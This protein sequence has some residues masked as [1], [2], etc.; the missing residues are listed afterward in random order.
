MK[1]KSIQNNSNE[2][3]F[4]HFNIRFLYNISA[5]HDQGID[6]NYLLIATKIIESLHLC[7]LVWERL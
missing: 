2:K 7:D 1:S 5:K 3:L 4:Q 6:T